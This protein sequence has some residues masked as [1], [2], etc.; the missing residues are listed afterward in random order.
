MTLVMHA[1]PE[2]S[3]IIGVVDSVEVHSESEIIISRTLNLSET[4]PYN[5]AIRYR[6]YQIMNLPDTELTKYQTY[7]I[8]NLSVKEHIR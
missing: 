5:K 7:H 2:K 4:E 6:I 1:L 8:P 3:F